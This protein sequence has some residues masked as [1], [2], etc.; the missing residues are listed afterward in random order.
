[1]T[2]PQGAVYAAGVI[3]L[4]QPPPQFGIPCLSPFGTKVETYLR[5]VD[6]PYRT[7]PGDP[8]RGPT[9]KIPY[10]ELEGRIIGDSSDILDELRRHHGITLDDHLTPVQRATGLVVRRTL[11]EHLYWVLVYA[12]WFE[13]SGWEHTEQFFRKMLPPVI[14]GL[15]LDKVIRRSVR[16][17]LHGQGLGR[18]KPDDLYRRGGEDVDAVAAILGEQT[19]LFGDRPTS[20]DCTLFA[21]T[22]GML[23]H[24]AENPLKRRMA[25]HA[26]LV[27]YTDRMYK[28]YFGAHPP[29]SSRPR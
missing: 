14:G 16:T 4:F 5:M 29:G 28:Q 6:L 15:L 3:T 13:P 19:Y 21:F 8:R 20:Y 10:I 27:A 18:H 17:A 23:M 2:G 26:N 22:S 25:G 12:R 7:R 1:M 9:G 11:E 24:P